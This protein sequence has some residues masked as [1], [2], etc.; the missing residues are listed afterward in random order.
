MQ[1]HLA[2]G[3]VRKARS[4]V[5]DD[6]SDHKDF[7]KL[8]RTKNNILILF[9]SNNKAAEN[10]IKLFDSAAETVRGEATT[11]LIECSKK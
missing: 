7:K 9:S 6:I 8:L 3:Q 11:V 5:I 10:V 1:I 4:P 2:V